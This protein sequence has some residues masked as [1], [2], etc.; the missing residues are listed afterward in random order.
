M[1]TSLGDEEQCNALEVRGVVPANVVDRLLQVIH[2]AKIGTAEHE[3]ER[4]EHRQV[5]LLHEGHVRVDVVHQHVDDPARTDPD[6][7]PCDENNTI[8]SRGEGL[9]VLSGDEDLGRVDE[10]DSK[11]SIVDG[12]DSVRNLDDVRPD[13]AFRDA[14][15][16]CLKAA[17]L[18]MWGLRLDVGL[19]ERLSV[20][21]VIVHDHEG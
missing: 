18:E 9:P 10:A 14:V 12:L 13:R 21:M 5:V 4:A 2:R 3:D 8:L 11:P 16:L 15:R 7:V 1:R 20:R 17:I 19:I 6:P